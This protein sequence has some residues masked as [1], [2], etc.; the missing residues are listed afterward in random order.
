[1]CGVWKAVAIKPDMCE[2]VATLIYTFWEYGDGGM[3]LL[4]SCQV[5]KSLALF[6]K[7]SGKQLNRSEDQLNR[8]LALHALVEGL[9]IC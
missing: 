7:I 3:I 1:M 5:I 9:G 6:L 2:H 4:N 8:F